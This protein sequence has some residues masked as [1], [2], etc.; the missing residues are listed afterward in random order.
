VHDLTPLTLYS[1]NVDLGL[2]DEEARRQS[3]VH[4]TP[5]VDA[6][7]LVAVGASETSEFIRQTRLMWDAWPAQRP[8]GAAGPLVVPDR[9]HFD[10]VVDF[11]DAKSA[12]AQSAFALL[13]SDAPAVK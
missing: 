11:T 10:V 13:S 12:L 6:P 9:H 2:D 5:R 3:P 7:L 8:P 1:W 4:A